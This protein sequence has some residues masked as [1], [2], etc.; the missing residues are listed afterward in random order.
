MNRETFAALLA[1]ARTLD[2]GRFPPLP[3]LVSEPII[4]ALET[5]LGGRLPDDYRWFLETYNTEAFGSAI[6]LSALPTAPDFILRRKEEGAAYFPP[7]FV[8]ISEDGCG[9][10][11]GLLLLGGM[12]TE[13]VW[14]WVHDTGELFLA[15]PTVLD[16]IA[17]QTFQ[18]LE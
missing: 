11:A 9:N 4:Q 6:L 12:L 1:R 8:P 13:R 2:S 14:N 3:S 17:D 15:H 7:D 16:H 10:S 18:D 5:T